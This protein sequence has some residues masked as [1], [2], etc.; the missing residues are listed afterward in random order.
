MI[1]FLAKDARIIN[2]GS[3][4]HYAGIF[5]LSLPLLI[6][7]VPIDFKIFESKDEFIHGTYSITKLLSHAHTI[8]LVENQNLEAYTVHPGGVLTDIFHGTGA[9]LPWILESIIWRVASLLLLS[10]RQGALTPLYVA[11]SPPNTFPIGS[12]I[13]DVDQLYM[14]NHIASIESSNFKHYCE[15]IPS[16]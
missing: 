11:L 3:I 6:V 4:A 16:Q 5:L 10:A 15:R 13:A 2:L 1:P 7:S 14:P 12:F 8:D 9:I